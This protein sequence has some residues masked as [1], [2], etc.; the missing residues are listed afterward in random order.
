MIDLV[1]GK[2]YKLVSNGFGYHYTTL[3]ESFDDLAGLRN[4]GK[5]L[6]YEVPWMLLS[7]SESVYYN[8]ALEI[9]CSHSIGWI[10]VDIRACHVEE[11]T[12]DADR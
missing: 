7:I 4:Y 6:G 1:P 2:L 11:A 5:T 9:L 10:G 8:T 3:F 12:L